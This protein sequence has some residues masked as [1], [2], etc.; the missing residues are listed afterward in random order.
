MNPVLLL[1][2]AATWAMVGLVWTM[3]LV[4]YPLF[5]RVGV[6]EFRAWHA[7]HVQRTTLIVGPLA[8]VEFGSALWLLWQGETDDRFLVSLGALAVALGSTFFVQVPLHAKL[9]AGFDPVAH[10]RLVRTNWLRTGAWTLRGVL[11][12]H[13]LARP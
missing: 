6:A 8:L 3:Q 7:S 2:A 13:L 11:L 10:G 5:A 4:Q 12:L 1:H 9:S